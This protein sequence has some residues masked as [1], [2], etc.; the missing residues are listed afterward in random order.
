[1]AHTLPDSTA[2]QRVL[3]KCGFRDVGSVIYPEDGL[4]WRFER[5]RDEDAV[6]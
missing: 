3:S 6:E 4:V 5:E 1:M 2:S